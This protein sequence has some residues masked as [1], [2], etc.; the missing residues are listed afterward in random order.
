MKTKIKINM[1]EINAY[2]M[3]ETLETINQK[4]DF[5]QNM[6]SLLGLLFVFSGFFLISSIIALWIYISISFFIFSAIFILNKIKINIKNEMK[7]NFKE[8]LQ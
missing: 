2:R 1:D 4:F 7:K 5:M 8:E 6:A 3:M